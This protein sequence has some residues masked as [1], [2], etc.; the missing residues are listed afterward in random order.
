M[1]NARSAK[2]AREK[3]A[4][5]QAEAERRAARRRVLVAGI[6]VVVA[7]VVAVAATVLVRSL[8]K[9]QADK[10]AEAVAPPA[11]LYNGVSTVGG[12]VLY[13]KDTAKVTVDVYEDFMCPV[14]RKFEIDNGPLLQ[15]YIDDGKIKI[16]Y[17]I[18]AIL[19]RASM[20]TQYSTRAANALASVVN[21]TPTAALKFHVLLLE[22]QPEEG[23]SGLPD[24][25][26]IDLAQKAGANRSAVEA[27]VKSLHYKGW[28][29]KITENFSK[30]FPPAGTPTIAVNGTKISDLSGASLVSAIDTALAK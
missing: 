30:T 24:S 3:A 9:Q 27:D 25:T 26:L 13:G 17:H 6:A 11:N 23:T 12:G 5:M 8:Q 20:G 1:A 4:E 19:D 22:N 7:V 28:V 2:S 16:V 29:S 21:N 10:A 18:V 14:C 15:K